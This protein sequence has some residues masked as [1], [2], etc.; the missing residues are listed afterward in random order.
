M[1]SDLPVVADLAPHVG[2]ACQHRG[3]LVTLTE[4]KGVQAR[5]QVS[6]PVFLA[7]H[8]VISDDAKGVLHDEI[9]EV[10]HCIVAPLDVLG[11]DRG[12][13]REVGRVV[14]GGNGLGVL[15]LQSVVPLLEVGLFS[16]VTT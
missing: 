7:L 12:Q 16:H 3:A 6:L 13:E 8:A 5:V 11:R 10:I 4:L 2:E 14:Q 9:R 15:G 1:V